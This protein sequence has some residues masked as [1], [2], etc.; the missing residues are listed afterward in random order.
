MDRERLKLYNMIEFSN[1]SVKFNESDF[2]DVI[3]NES[4]IQAQSDP[5]NQ[6]TNGQTGASVISNGN[7]DAHSGASILQ[8]HSTNVHGE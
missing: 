6:A 5:R 1:S 8:N 7:V 3:W 4:A 2:Y